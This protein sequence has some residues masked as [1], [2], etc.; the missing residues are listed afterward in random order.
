MISLSSRT[1]INAGGSVI[2]TC[3]AS[4]SMYSIQWEGPGVTPT[5]ANPT[6]S[7]GMVSSDLTLS[8]IST[9]QAGLYTC[10]TTL[11]GSIS[12]STIITVQ[13]KLIQCPNRWVFS[14]SFCSISQ[15]RY[16]HPMNVP[17]FH[18]C[19]S[20]TKYVFYPALP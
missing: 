18:K 5:P 19:I 7:G 10:T 11:G 15:C 4:N 2:L 3:T 8:E 17:T 20:I 6:T 12:T 14:F 9:S 1:S 16:Y 13:S